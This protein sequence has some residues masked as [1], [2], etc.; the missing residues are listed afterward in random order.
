MNKIN[1]AKTYIV[2]AC[3][4]LGALGSA[5]NGTI[6]WPEAFAIVVPALTAVTVRHG[7]ST[8]AAK[9]AE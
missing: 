9:K 6:T 1:G 8:E 4:I 5:W 2:A 3:A 7:I